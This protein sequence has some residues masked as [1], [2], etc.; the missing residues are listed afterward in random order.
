VNVW[1]HT[2]ADDVGLNHIKHF[3]G[4]S[5]HE[6][7]PKIPVIPKLT[8]ILKHDICTGNELTLFES[9]I[10]C[11]VSIRHCEPIRAGIVRIGTCAD[12]RD[13]I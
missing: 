10:A 4:V 1:G 6:L 12:N 9:S 2:D 11:G 3:L 13:S 7:R 8:G 5:E